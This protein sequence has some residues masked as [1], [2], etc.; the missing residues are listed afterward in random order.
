M[1]AAA[2]DRDDEPTRITRLE[3]AEI[4]TRRAVRRMRW[5]WGALMLVGAIFAA[6]YVARDRVDHFA[7]SER[8]DELEQRQQ[9]ADAKLDLVLQAQQSQI[10]TQK[11]MADQL[12]KMFDR[13]MRGRGGR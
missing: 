9:R 8:V 3:L 1:N 12:D 2:H 7:T 10:D 5:W 13:M 11:R 6:G 4:G